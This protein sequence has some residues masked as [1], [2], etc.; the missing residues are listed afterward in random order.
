M[1][2]TYTLALFQMEIAGRINVIFW[3]FMVIAVVVNIL[4]TAVNFCS[5]PGFVAKL[6][7]YG[8]ASVERSADL[9][10]V[11]KR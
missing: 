11:P 6:F 5:V 2:P 9:V 3:F 10:Q 1:L 7:L 8:K 4:G